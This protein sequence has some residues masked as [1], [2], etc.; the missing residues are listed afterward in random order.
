MMAPD[1][2]LP[3]LTLVDG[4][5]MAADTGEVLDVEDPDVATQL[6]GETLDTFARARV[7]ADALAM[8]LEDIEAMALSTAR[9]TDKYKQI[10]ARRQAARDTMARIE[11]TLGG[12][13]GERDTKVSID[14]GRVLVTW[15]K[16]RETWSLAKPASWYGTEVACQDL[17]RRLR[18]RWDASLGHHEALLLAV[19]VR[20]WL[21]PTAKVSEPGAPSITVRTNGAGR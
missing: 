8:Q 19:L 20:D 16:P 10:A 18:D 7:E 15:G 4:R 1:T 17:A 21:A 9:A 2:V 11:A 6:F 14:T 12:M 13:F 5:V 3:A